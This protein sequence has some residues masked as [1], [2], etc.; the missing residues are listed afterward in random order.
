MAIVGQENTP[1]WVPPNLSDN[2]ES[3]DRGR[4]IFRVQ[5]NM[6]NLLNTLTQKLPNELYFIGSRIKEH[7]ERIENLQITILSPDAFFSD[8]SLCYEIGKLRYRIFAEEMGWKIPTVIKLNGTSA[9]D[10]T[11]EGEYLDLDLHDKYSFH[12][13][14]R[15]TKS[16]MIVACARL[17]LP[18]KRATD[19]TDQSIMSLTDL[20]DIHKDEEGNP[21]STIDILLEI[22]GNEDHPLCPLVQ[23]YI[24]GLQAG[25]CGELQRFL[26]DTSA[27][28][29][30][31]STL[32]WYILIAALVVT[33]ETLGINILSAQSERKFINLIAKLLGATLDASN[34][35]FLNILNSHDDNMLVLYDLTKRE[36]DG[37]KL[38]L[39]LMNLLEIELNKNK[40]ENKSEPEEENEFEEQ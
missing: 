14:I 19:L 21:V 35:N 2:H 38:L 6:R 27:I 40:S 12:V 32:I 9:E 25:T 29:R 33:A 37:L 3:G 18:N 13:V 28:D 5:I 20:R 26:V 15:D 1:P 17:E 8:R 30:R 22:E 23:R 11:V 31:V 39:F 10:S 7:E 4:E 24:N 34:S 16:G 36:A